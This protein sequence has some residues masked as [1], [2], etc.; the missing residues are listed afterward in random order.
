M[1]DVTVT[2]NEEDRGQPEAE[3]TVQGHDEGPRTP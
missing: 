3:G 2:V 1:S